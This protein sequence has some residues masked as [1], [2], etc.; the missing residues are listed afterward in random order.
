MESARKWKEHTATQEFAGAF[1]NVCEQYHEDNETRSTQIEEFLI[2]RALAIGVARRKIT[3]ITANPN[4]WAKHLAPWY[5][6]QC[7]EAKREYKECKK[8]KG[9]KHGDTLAAY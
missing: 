5:N 7:R 8:R 9:K 4:R 2:E 6:D 3:R 1:R